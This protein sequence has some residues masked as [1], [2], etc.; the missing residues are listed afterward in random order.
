MEEKT[1]KTRQKGMNILEIKAGMPPSGD[2]GGRH[3]DRGSRG[4]K[5][6]VIAPRSR[7][8]A[9]TDKDQKTRWGN[10][11]ATRYPGA[12]APGSSRLSGPGQE[13][14]GSPAIL[15][16]KADHGESEMKVR[17]VLVKVYEPG[18]LQMAWQQVRANAGAA[19]IDQMVF[20]HDSTVAFSRA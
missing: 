10:R 6:V 2:P 12:N 9:V 19:G 16:V 1:L 11:I 8:R 3:R 15:G 18:R 13:A 5:V 14:S 17:E 4:R 7:N 20:L